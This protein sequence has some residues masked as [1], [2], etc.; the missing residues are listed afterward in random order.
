MEEVRY[1]KLKKINT[2]ILITTLSLL[3]MVLMTTLI[4]YQHQMSC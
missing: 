4:K 2:L 1:G 3:E